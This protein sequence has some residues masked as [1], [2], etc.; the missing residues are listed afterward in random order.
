MIGSF[1]TCFESLEESMRVPDMTNENE[2]RKSITFGE[3]ALA[4]ANDYDSLYVIDSEDDSYVEYITKGDNKELVKRDFGDDFYAAVIHNCREQVYP[5]DQERFL[6]S[7]KKENVIEVLK[8]GKSFTL[9]Y[10]LMVNGEALHYFLKT[11][12]GTDQKVIIGVQ[13]VDEQRKREIQ[14]SK[15]SMTFRHIAGALASRYEAIYYIDLDSNAYTQYSSSDEYARLG[16]ARQGENFFAEAVDD[17]KKYIHPDDTRKVLSELEKDSLMRNLRE[18]GSLT[19]TYRQQLGDR[20][21]YVSMIVV[22]P[23]NDEKHVV[24]GVIN[25]DAQIRREQDM[26]AESRVFG[27]M[28]LALATRYEVIY[29]VNVLTN[30]YSEY[31]ASE[32]YTKLKVGT[33]GEDFFTDT[34]NNM[35]RDIY[36]E[37]LP[38]MAAAME[39]ENLL[40]TLGESGKLLINYRLML[41]G[42]PQYVTLFAVHTKNDNDHIIVAVENV[43]EAKRKELEFERAIGSA[44]D[45]ANKDAL[46]SVKNKHAYAQAEM[47]LDEQINEESCGAFAV[48]VCDVN[49]LKQVN[50]QQGHSAG[51]E[52]IKSA[53]NIICNTFKHS[54]VFRIGGDEFVVLLKG[55]DYEE[56]NALMAEFGRRQIE[57]KKSGVVTLA[58][59]FSEFQPERDIRVQDVFERADNLMYENKRFIKGENYSH[60]LNLPLSKDA[61]MQFYVLF[62][63]LVS[64]MTDIEHK[65]V[66]KIE[67]LLIEISSMFRLSKGVTRVYRN[68]QEEKEGGGETLCCYD[69]GVEGV[70]VSTLRVVTSVLSSATM[71]VYMSPDEPPLT[72]D[73]RWKVEL[74][75]RTT[76][77]FVSRN[78][79]KDIVEELAFYDESGYPNLR[80]LNTY[81]MRMVSTGKIYGKVAFRYNLRHFGLINQEFGRDTGDAIMKTHYQAMKELC[82]P[83]GFV[84]R[85]GGDNF[86]GISEGKNAKK[87]IKYLSG[88]RVDIGDVR[89]NLQTSAGIFVISDDYEINLPGDV[90]GRIIGAYN[91]ARG[92]GKEIIVYYDDSLVSRKVKSMRVQQLFPVALKDREFRPYYQPKVNVNTREMEGAEALCRWFHGDDMIPPSDFIP[93]LEE[94][95]D[96]CRLDLYMLERVCQDL[97]RWMDEGKRIVRVS[98]NLSRKNV[99]N[100][101]LSDT[102]TEIV[103]RYGIPHEYIEIELTETTTDVEFNDL[104][105]IVAGLHDAG[106]YTSVDDFGVGFSSLNLIRDVPWN[107]VKIDKSFLPVEEDDENSTRSIMFRNVVALSR[108]LGLGCI[109]EG[110][111]T[112]QQV[113][114]LRENGCDYAQGYYFDRPLPVEEFEKRLLH[115]HYE[116]K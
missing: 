53:C 26:L 89:V 62:E 87:A 1:V 60:D 79:L 81:L 61:T 2:N 99:M 100:V 42:R 8:N 10:R 91:L 80:S 76:L 6:D 56:R 71:T 70:E 40:N 102:I 113:D 49:G 52:Y 93:M 111:E 108:Q 69:T 43:D 85:L 54:P 18:S 28:A 104:K 39:K 77:S 47:Q 82:G 106:I 20:S 38:M 109:A 50:D 90:L 15:E 84:A 51:D 115:R 57:N 29:H 63:Q 107:V 86:V 75:M 14:A 68:L 30:E 114:V 5:E 55:S 22:H 66:A 110:V 33:K 94:T 105:R 92:G 96:I 44:M 83:D 45:M 25:V 21:K 112:K 97:R 48:V 59:G 73:E 65:D 36:P 19:L 88:A 9:N 17:V 32:K 23:K 4:L 103:D 78:R 37:D 101:G 31:S 24:M 64:A 46:T 11:I 116:D 67:A 74:V 35:K 41:D 7:F 72:E 95:N 13:N 3:I 27:E 98:V 16:T 34:Q 58:Y 12:R